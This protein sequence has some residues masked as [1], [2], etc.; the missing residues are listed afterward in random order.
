MYNKP[1]E[2]AN[3]EETLIHWKYQYERYHTTRLRSWRTITGK[4]IDPA[5]LF[6]LV[7]LGLATVKLFNDMWL[8]NQF[9]L[10]DLTPLVDP[11]NDY[12]WQND[13]ND[14]PRDTVEYIVYLEPRV[15][16]K[17][18]Q[19]AINLIYDLGNG[20]NPLDRI[21]SGFYDIVLDADIYQF[22]MT[23]VKPFNETLQ[24]NL[25]WSSIQR[26][27][28]ELNQKTADV[29][30]LTDNFKLEA[31]K[32]SNWRKSLIDTMLILVYGRSDN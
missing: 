24:S 23:E 26:E 19:L 7:E 28:G 11:D 2:F 10:T 29:Y 6:Q 5:C 17:R 32:L 25:A 14:Y 30:A 22:I 15:W 31:N 3:L 4:W 21:N 8:D 27:I 12:W 13:N 9:Y 1:D 18:R 20:H 16:G